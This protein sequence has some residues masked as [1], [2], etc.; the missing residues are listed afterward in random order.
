MNMRDARR[1][2]NAISRRAAGGMMA[3][4]L[5]APGLARA[6]SLKAFEQRLMDR[7]E[8]FQPMDEPAPDFAF[9]DAD[10]HAVALRDLRDKVLVLNFIY[11]RC[12]D[13]CPL[14]TERM[15]K[16]RR[17]ILARG[18]HDRVRL[19]TITA[20]P[21]RDTPSVMKAYATQHGIEPPDWLFLT[22]GPDRPTATRDLSARYHN[23][24]QPAPDGSIS[25]GTVFHVIDG[26]GR[27]R[28]NFHGL[29]WQPEDL[30]QFVTEL[31]NLRTASAA[32]NPSFLERLER[33][34]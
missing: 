16:I 9:E 19:V 7:D 27:W 4:A 8:Y 11:T 33:I 17:M 23:R 29:Q 14:Q 32:A 21:V 6:R 24:Y 30:V 20:D 34:F 15:A 3:V 5:L 12:P 26:E 28:G 1:P 2:S 18:I 25:H 22:S 10:G 13:I 31:T